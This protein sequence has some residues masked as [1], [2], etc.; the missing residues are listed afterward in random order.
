MQLGDLDH[1]T[2]TAAEG[3]DSLW[4]RASRLRQQ[5]DEADAF[6]VPAEGADWQSGSA[7]REN[8]P[9]AAGP[10][11]DTTMAGRGANMA[12]VLDQVRS[13]TKQR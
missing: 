13:C 7:E 2:A 12:A 1:E 11:V 8:S 9:E 10:K 5:V 3:H 6:R 4:Q